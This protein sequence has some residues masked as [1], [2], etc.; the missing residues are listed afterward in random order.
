MSARPTFERRIRVVIAD[1]H[2]LV[3]RMVSTI[4]QQYTHIDVVAEAK[5]GL[6]AVEEAKKSK[7]DVV[8]LNISMPRLNGF[9]AARQ[10]QKLVP[11]SAIVILSTHADEQF[12]KVAKKIGVRVYISKT[13]VGNSL[14]QAVEAAA[15]GEDFIVM[16]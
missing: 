8:I 11:E 5:D 3:R 15:N 13:Q 6:Q 7:P 1:D 10:I 2:P 9:E 14:V 12:V 4:L 16:D